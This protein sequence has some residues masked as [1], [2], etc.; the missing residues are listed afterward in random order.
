MCCIPALNLP[1]ISIRCAAVRGTVYYGQPPPSSPPRY[2]HR[3]HHYRAPPTT[4]GL[5]RGTE[6]PIHLILRFTHPPPPPAN[7]PG[8]CPW[9]S[10]ST[11]VPISASGRPPSPGPMEHAGSLAVSADYLSIMAYLLPHAGTTGT[12]PTTG[13]TPPSAL[14]GMPLFTTAASRTS[15]GLDLLA[16]AASAALTRTRPPPLRPTAETLLSSGPF[17][18]AACLPAK[19]VKKIVDLDFVEMSKLSMLEDDVPASL[20]RPPPPRPPVTDISM[21][22][23]RYSAMAA[24]LATRFPHKAPE[25]FAY[26]ATIVRAERNYEGKRWV[27]YDRQFRREALSRKSLD[28]SV[29]DSRLYNEA[30]TGRARTISRCSFCL[31]DD[32]QCPRN[33]SR[34]LFGW[35]PE[36]TG[37]PQQLTFA[38]IPSTRPL[39]GQS[40]AQEACRRY[41]DGRC[42]RQRCKYAHCCS[43]CGGAHPA[44]RCQQRPA[45]VPGRSRSPAR[46]TPGPGARFP[47]ASRYT[48]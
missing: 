26:Q 1:C 46:P 48:N 10:A 35:L 25:L 33:P 38:G 39:T 20:G 3:R 23:E 9:P 13:S 34:A 8:R 5:E 30:F 15:S 11:I 42:N 28:W 45:P 37:W 32:S 6:W 19:V 40:T 18:P 21:W 43:S 22:V 47:S 4:G 7:S 27:A 41:N 14:A 31:Q 44:F 12:P 2:V 17:N 24:I 29:T 36:V 16:A